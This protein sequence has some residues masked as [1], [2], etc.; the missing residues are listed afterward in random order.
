MRREKAGHKS[1]G[2]GDNR[3]KEEPHTAGNMKTSNFWAERK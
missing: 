3:K 2:R 1:A